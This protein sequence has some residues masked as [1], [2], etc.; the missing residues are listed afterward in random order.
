MVL[1]F[2]SM[3]NMVLATNDEIDQ[4]KPNEYKKNEIELNPRA[5]QQENQSTENVP[6]EFQ[7]LTFKQQRKKEEDEWQEYLFTEVGQKKSTLSSQVE[8]LKLFSSPPSSISQTIDEPALQK[9]AQL[10]W[11]LIGLIGIAVILLFGLLLPR[12]IEASR[13]SMN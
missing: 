2:L 11:V 4:L 7:N 10:K 12:M 5:L 1:L 9:N 13:K 6:E 8:E 3:E